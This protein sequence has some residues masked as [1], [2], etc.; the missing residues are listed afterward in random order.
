[1]MMRR[2]ERGWCEAG[3]DAVDDVYKRATLIPKDGMLELDDEE[4]FLRSQWAGTGKNL[5][6]NVI[7]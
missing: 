5:S 6:V 4:K 1:M 3:A 2:E 7:M